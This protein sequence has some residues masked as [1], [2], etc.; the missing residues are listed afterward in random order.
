MSVAQS[1]RNPD[2]RRILA[3][4]VGLTQT[5]ADIAA[6]LLASGHPVVAV[7][8]DPSERRTA[9]RRIRA[10]LRTLKTEGLIKSSPAALMRRIAVSDNFSALAE[11]AIVVDATWGFAA[12]K[13]ALLAK[14]ESAASPRAVI[15][16]RTS[17]VPTTEM[18]KRARRPERVIGLHWAEPAHLTRFMEIVCGKKTSRA[19]AEFTQA[20]AFKWGKEPGLLR[21]EV[22][23]FLANRIMYAML[24]EAFHL[25]DTGVCAPEDI[26]RSLRNDMG[27][28]ITLAGPFRFMDLTG[29]PDFADFM[30]YLLPHLSRGTKMPKLMRKM[31]RTGT[32]GVANRRGY[33][34]YTA[35]S[36]KQW[37]AR[38]EKFTREISALARKYPESNL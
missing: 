24:R 18:A 5:G 33:Y 21:K 38:F 16:L 7:A 12:S 23:G 30:K 28:W 25:V 22:P 6:R 2:P 17:I 27:F 4:V 10:A 9:A 15:A 3:G 8:P 31:L 34:R 29:V 37:K 35:R 14:L 32:R 26:D 11:C 19:T 36:A 13:R 1:T 20:L